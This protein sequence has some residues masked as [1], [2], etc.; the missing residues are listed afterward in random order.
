MEVKI[1]KPTM[2]MKYAEELE[3]LKSTD[4]GKKPE[5]WLMSP[6]AVRTFIL[7]SCKAKRK[8]II[9]LR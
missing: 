4:T 2:E 5:N 8:M 9:F 7:G 3:A 1:L 6:K